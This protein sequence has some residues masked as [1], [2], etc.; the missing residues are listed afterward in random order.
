MYENL[1]K[2]RFRHPTPTHMASTSHGASV[3]SSARPILRPGTS[4]QLNQPRP[5]DLSASTSSF[6]GSFLPP[7][8][9]N[10]SRPR[11]AYWPG[12]IGSS[13]GVAYFHPPPSQAPVQQQQNVNTSVAGGSSYYE[14]QHPLLLGHSTGRS[15]TTNPS[16]LSG[17]QVTFSSPQVQQSGQRQTI[18]IEEMTAIAPAMEALPSK[19]SEETL[20]KPKTETVC[21]LFVPCLFFLMI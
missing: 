13:R 9:A 2:P 11:P 20:E 1:W 15:Q 5:R 21:S 19:S 10:I 14:H 6:R 3:R 18:N 16:L 7:P 4:F 8:P 12:L 17:G